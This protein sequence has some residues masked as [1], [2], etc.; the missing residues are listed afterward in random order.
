[1]A[2]P[3][4]FLVSSICRTYVEMFGYVHICVCVWYILRVCVLKCYCPNS[5]LCRR[6]ICCGP[7]LS[8]YVRVLRSERRAVVLRGR[9]RFRITRPSICHRLMSR[10]TPRRYFGSFCMFAREVSVPEEEWHETC[11]TSGYNCL[12]KCICHTRKA[13][14]VG[15]V[16]SGWS[17]ISCLKWRRRRYIYILR[18][19]VWGCQIGKKK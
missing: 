2:A 6:T 17:M 15:R 1:M 3:I 16:L 11:T 9:W 5:A 19:G 18:G 4:K 10:S 12:L 14:I 8:W 7:T 13:F